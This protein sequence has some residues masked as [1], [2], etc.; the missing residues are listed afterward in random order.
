MTG[1][2][3]QLRSI[4]AGVG[5]HQ[6]RPLILRFICLTVVGD[7]DRVSCKMKAMVVTVKV[8]ELCGY[9][10]ALRSCGVVPTVYRIIS[11]Y[12]RSI[13]LH[14]TSNTSVANRSHVG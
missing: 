1:A 4:G 14:F 2:S 9:L 10:A 7:F 13:D 5:Y 12:H 11:F 8:G 3:A 6:Y